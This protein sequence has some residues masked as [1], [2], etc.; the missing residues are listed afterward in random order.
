MKDK[1]ETMHVTFTSS[2][3]VF[4]RI[5]GISV[6][7]PPKD[8]GADAFVL[9][10]GKG[11]NVTNDLRIMLNPGNRIKF[12]Y[13]DHVKPIIYHVRA[14]VDGTHVVVR[15]RRNEQWR[16]RLM[17]WDFL[18]EEHARGNLVFDGTDQE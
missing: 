4:R 9:L 14:V 6:P 15:V 11:D 18:A 13:A 16:Y 7:E 17:R 10:N 2:E 5:N 1:P 8:D 3:T 12:D